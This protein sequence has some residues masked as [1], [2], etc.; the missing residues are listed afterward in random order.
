MIRYWQAGAACDMVRWGNTIPSAV[1]GDMFETKEGEKF[2]WNNPEH[3]A[4]PF[5]KEG[6]ETRDPRLY[7][8][9]VVNGD[10]FR[11]RT[12]ELYQ[13]GRESWDGKGSTLSKSVYLL[14][15]FHSL[16]MRISLKLSTIS[17]DYS[18]KYASSHPSQSLP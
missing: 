15:F 18:K 4:N 5:F 13:G 10:A 8:T 7:E 2:D 14:L 3:A 16:H 9:L 11:G 6:K 1:L 12:A 17:C